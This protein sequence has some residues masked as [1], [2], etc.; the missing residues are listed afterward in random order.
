[1][2]FLG[3]SGWK[4]FPV[5]RLMQRVEPNIAQK[6]QKKSLRKKEKKSGRKFEENAFISFKLTMNG[7]TVS[8]FS[9]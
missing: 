7:F 8:W 9:I 1:M 4:I 2:G 5:A 6:S 3:G